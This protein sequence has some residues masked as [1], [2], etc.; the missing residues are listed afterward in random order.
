MLRLADLELAA[1]RQPW[2]TMLSLGR[3]AAVESEPP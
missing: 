3:E 1:S 2:L